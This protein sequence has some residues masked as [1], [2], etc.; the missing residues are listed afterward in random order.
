MFSPPRGQSAF[1][2][3][4]N[5]SNFRQSPFFGSGFGNPSSFAQA[6]TGKGG[7]GGLLGRFFGSGASGAT[8]AAKSALGSGGGI[9]Q[10][11]ANIQQVMNMAQSATP[12]I[13]QYGPMV[14]NIP[15]MLSLIKAFN[16]DDDEE[17]ETKEGS[18]GSSDEQGEKKTGNK[19]EVKG[20][21]INKMETEVHSKNKQQQKKKSSTQTGTST[22][23]LFI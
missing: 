23:K 21:N 15:T 9:T 20:E 12:I 2:Q 7:I 6:Q 3:F 5:P 13:Q 16:E 18:S 14:K 1:R 4:S 19:I 10:T 8:G 11:L 17:D 22:P